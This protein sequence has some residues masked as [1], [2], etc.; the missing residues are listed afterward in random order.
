MELAAVFNRL[1]AAIRIGVFETKQL[2]LITTVAVITTNIDR[3][4]NFSLF[5]F[6]SRLA[7]AD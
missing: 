1:S 5:S 6:D 3:A 2:D 4:S 7:T